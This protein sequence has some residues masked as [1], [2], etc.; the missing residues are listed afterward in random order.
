MFVTTLICS[1]NSNNGDWLWNRPWSIVCTPCY[2]YIMI[3]KVKNKT[4]VLSNTAY[5]IIYIF[6][7]TV[8]QIHLQG[9][10]FCVIFSL[11]I[12]FKRI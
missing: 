5:I 6:D 1:I 11:S 8:K 9:N 4:N 12:M 10:L 3:N 2:L 7:V